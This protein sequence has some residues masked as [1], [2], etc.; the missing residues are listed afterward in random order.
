MQKQKIENKKYKTNMKKILTIA[1]LF[2]LM[3]GA[4][5]QNAG[6]KEYVS[7]MITFRDTVMLPQDTLQKY[8]VVIQTQSGRMGTA[9]I[10]AT[11]YQSFLSA[12]LVERVQ[13]STRVYLRDEQVNAVAAEKHECC[14]Q[15]EKSVR[16][17]L[18]PQQEILDADAEGWYV[19]ML[20]GGSS[21]RMDVESA[22]W[23]GT[24]Y[25]GRGL[26]LEARAGY[27]FNQWFGIRSGLDVVS[28][29]YGTRLNVVYNDAS[30]TY[31]TTYNN[32]Y[33]QLPVLADLSMGGEVCRIN[34][35]FGGYAGYW[36]SQWRHGYVYVAD[37]PRPFVGDAY[38]FVKGSDRRFDAGLAGGLGLSLRVASNWVLRF[39]GTY[40]HGLVST[41]KDYDM[42]NRTWTFGL[43]C[44]YHF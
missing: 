8:G 15:K 28:K 17:N 29:N 37:D 10:E 20:L 39:E 41:A 31:A 30:T 22:R 11:K 4:M 40:Y 21:H 38:S 26:N 13:P 32:V 2:A 16:Q 23:G 19:G 34:V 12:N 9:I 35:V 5:A 36:M 27:Q 24:W 18:I 33:L 6:M 7:A 43:G 3:G 14:K 25:M 44:T 1:M 42:Y